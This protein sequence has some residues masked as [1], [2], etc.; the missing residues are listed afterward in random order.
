MWDFQPGI[1]TVFPDRERW[2]LGPLLFAVAVD[3]AGGRIA[4][5][6]GATWPPRAVKERDCDICRSSRVVVLKGLLSTEWIGVHLG[7]ERWSCHRPA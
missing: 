1:P 2:A 3:G 4:T 6:R 5:D 7:G